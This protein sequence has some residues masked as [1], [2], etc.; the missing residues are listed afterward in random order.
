MMKGFVVLLAALFVA[1]FAAPAT[2][3][4]SFFGT[5]RVLP[6]FYSNFDF[7]DNQPDAPVN[8]EAGFA[9]GE[10]IRSELRLGWKA[11]GDKWKIMFIAEADVINEK[12][13]ADRSFYNTGTKGTPA[14]ADAGGEVGIEGGEL[15]YTFAPALGLATG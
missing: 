4:I 9:T 15:N 11:G 5:A 14:V 3:E 13:T 2:A 10:H 7:N 6:T 8:N 12:D 1:M